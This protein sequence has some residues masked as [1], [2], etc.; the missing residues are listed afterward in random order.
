M[1]RLVMAATALMI[2]TTVFSAVT[3][4]TPEQIKIV[5]VNDQE[6][7]TGLFSNASHTFKVD[8]GQHQI[9]VRY[10]EYF[11][12]YDNSHD[13]VRS[14]IIIL[15]TPALVD[16]QTYHLG[17]INAPKDFEQAQAYKQQPIIGLY[18]ANHQLLVQ[19]A[20]AIS[21]Q[22]TVFKGLNSTQDSVV[23]LTSKSTQQPAALY[24]PVVQK[25]SDSKLVTER[26]PAHSAVNGSALIDVWKK[27]TPEQRQQFLTWL[28]T[29]TQ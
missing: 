2:S 12:H 14:G 22:K 15:L 13:I 19:Q 6:V 9:S 23:D 18:N 25:S 10:T 4:K 3:I 1:F 27:S 29:Q 16:G 8:A 26:V 5:A 17:L 28:T 21:A 7:K 11:Q 24:T 20:G